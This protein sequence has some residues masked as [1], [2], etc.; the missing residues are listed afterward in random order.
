LD[1]GLN[2]RTTLPDSMAEQHGR[3]TVTKGGIEF[4]SP[5]GPESNPDRSLGHRADGFAEEG[6]IGHNRN[7][8]AVGGGDTQGAKVGIDHQLD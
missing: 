7:A 8:V 5:K 4:K 2:Y 1:L 3:T 6:F